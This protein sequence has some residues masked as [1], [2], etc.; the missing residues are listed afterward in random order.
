MEDILVKI[1]D[2]LSEVPEANYRALKDISDALYNFKDELIEA[3]DKIDLSQSD[4]DLEKDIT[5]IINV[6]KSEEEFQCI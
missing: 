2:L 3:L 1:D 4:V 5:D 6:I